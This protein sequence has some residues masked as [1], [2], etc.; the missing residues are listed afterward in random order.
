MSIVNKVVHKPFVNISGGV[1]INLVPVELTFIFTGQNDV[2]VEF[3][4]LFFFE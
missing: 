4:C 2:P 3:T 1:Y